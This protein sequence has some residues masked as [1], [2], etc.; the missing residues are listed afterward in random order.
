MTTDRPNRAASRRA[1]LQDDLLADLRG[2]SP[3]PAAATPVTSPRAARRVLP[4]E[5]AKSDTPTLHLRLTPLRWSRPW[6]K[7]PDGPRAPIMLGIGP[8]QITLTGLEH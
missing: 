8:F 3:M 4:H 7:A 6:A 5:R 1:T 2:A